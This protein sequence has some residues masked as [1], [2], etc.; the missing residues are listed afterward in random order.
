MNEREK[1]KKKSTFSAKKLHPALKW[2]T[3]NS[4]R[5]NETNHFEMGLKKKRKI[6]FDEKIEA[7]GET[8]N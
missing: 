3:K 8:S 6:F 2:A 4:L 5:G 7:D 1:K